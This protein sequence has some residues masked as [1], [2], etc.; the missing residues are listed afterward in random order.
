MTFIPFDI[1]AH[2]GSYADIDTR[3]YMGL[4]PRRISKTVL[5]DAQAMLDQVTR[6]QVV[7]NQNHLTVFAGS[8]K[9]IH[10]MMYDFKKSTPLSILVIDPRI[11]SI[12]YWE[13]DGTFEFTAH[14]FPLD[15]ESM[16]YQ[17][18]QHEG[19]GVHTISSIITPGIATYLSETFDIVISHPS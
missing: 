5:K 12:Q 3:R 1:V 9:R 2:I 4:P 19:W 11:C 18:P 6:K 10:M 8:H 13:E 15:T 7:L 17:T 16:Y 14:V